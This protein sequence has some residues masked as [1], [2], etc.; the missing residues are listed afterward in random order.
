MR[1]PILNKFVI[2]Y[3][4]NLFFICLLT[5]LLF[6]WFG[7]SDAKLSKTAHQLLANSGNEILVSPAVYWEIAIKI[8]IGKYT[9]NQPYLPF[10]DGEIARNHF[11]VLP[12]EPRHTAELL[13]L[14]YHHR[15]PFDRLIIAQA[16]VEQTPII[17][18]DPMFDRYPVS[19]IW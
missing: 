15:D 7:L 16:I 1:T 8:S 12:V 19:R 14:P 6:L 4:N 17:S 10:I 2:F 3:Q 11:S 18:S 5:K 9:L 13:A